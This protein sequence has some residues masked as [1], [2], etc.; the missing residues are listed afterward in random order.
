MKT[1]VPASAVSCATQSYCLR[2][3]QYRCG[4]LSQQPVFMQA[5]RR[6]PQLVTHVDMDARLGL[7]L[8]LAMQVFSSPLHRIGAAVAAS[9][10]NRAAPRR[11]AA[12]SAV[13]ARGESLEDL[14]PEY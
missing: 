8:Q 14:M 6:T 5:E 1:A 9:G 4:P 11:M 13:P 2:R 12:I 3:P 10:Q 7:L